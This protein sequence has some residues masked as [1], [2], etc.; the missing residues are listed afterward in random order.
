MRIA[1]AAI[2]II[3][4]LVC[5]HAPADGAGA[6]GCGP[7]VNG[8]TI[9][10]NICPAL[11]NNKITIGNGGPWAFGHGDNHLLANG[12]SFVSA[13]NARLCAL[14]AYGAFAITTSPRNGVNLVFNY[15]EYQ[16]FAQTPH[17][18]DP[19]STAYF[20]NVTTG[21]G[22]YSSASACD[23]AAT[24]QALKFEAPPAGI[25]F[26]DGSCAVTASDVTVTLAPGYLNCCS[27][28]PSPPSQASYII[29][30][31]N[32][33]MEGGELEHGATVR[34][35]SGAANP[36]IKNMTISDIGGTSGTS[37]ILSGNRNQA[38]TLIGVTVHGCGAGGGGQNHNIYVSADIAGDAAATVRIADIKSYDVQGGG[39]TLKL[40]PE[41]VSVQCRVT[42]S[43]IGC[44]STG[45]GCQQNGVVDMPCGGNYLIDHSALERGPGGDNW[46]ML[47]MLEE[48]VG[49]ALCAPRAATN[50]LSLDHVSL[51]WDGRAP[52]ASV[53]SVVCVA[54]HDGEGNCETS[55]VPS[56][57]T[58]TISNSVIV[59]DSATHVSLILGA[60]CR[61]GGGNRA[62]ANRAAAAAG[63]HWSGTDMFGNLCC[64]FP[65]VPPK[66]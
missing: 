53:I 58:C 16:V 36:T 59:S 30:G 12:Q 20:R 1:I 65:W 21:K 54:K 48:P 8:A 39:W 15:A 13:I 10:D 64:A 43:F 18:C 35:E 46:F 19:P 37:C 28:A 25:P 40:R 49:P 29:E 62:Y 14:T 66:S 47:R 44:Q 52:G 41:C 26:W 33:T 9:G 27:L 56:G 7:Y 38:V 45:T 22:Y 60:G 23:A 11:P 55:D 57:T 32:I 4:S 42:T 50:N 63:E 17:L 24:G 34:V 31:N 61:D 5:A 51:I 6:S 3:L 2:F